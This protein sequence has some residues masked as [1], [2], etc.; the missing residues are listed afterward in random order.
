MTPAHKRTLDRFATALGLTLHWD[1]TYLP[2]GYLYEDG[3]FAAGFNLLPETELGGRRI[4]HD[5]AHWLVAPEEDKPL[6][7]FNLGPADFAREP[8]AA[9]IDGYID[10]MD[11]EGLAVEVEVMLATKL[12]GPKYG[13]AT[14]GVTSGNGVLSDRE[15]KTLVG[16]G[17]MT[18]KGV[19][20][21]WLV[22]HLRTAKDKNHA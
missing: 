11:E 13:K 21:P 10:V 14:L 18:P 9:K 3:H 8:R 15:L 1:L 16:R 4:L 22:T 20:A 2:S 6:P 12:F 7:N 19:F 17:L 5:I